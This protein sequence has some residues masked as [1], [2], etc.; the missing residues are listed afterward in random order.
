MWWS[1]CGQGGG[2]DLHHAGVDFLLIGVERVPGR[3]AVWPRRQLRVLPE[4]RPAS[5]AARASPRAAC[6][7][8]GRTCPLNLAIQSLGAW[9]G[10]WAV[11]G[12]VVGEERL[13]RARP[14][15]ACGSGRWR[16]RPCP[17]RRCSPV[18]SCGGSTG[19]VFSKSAGCH[20]SGV[21]AEEAVE[22]VEA[23]PGGPQVERPGLAGVPVGHVVVLAEPRR[24]CSR[25][26]CRISANVPQ[27]LGM[28]EL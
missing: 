24:C 7:S 11:P 21:A 19:L 17:G 14:R 1:Q 12:R 26:A 10:A 28:S 6:P 9:C 25:S 23:Q 22:V 27:L 18:R 8:P 20:W 15:A 2:V 5:S 4:R 16:G 13:V 3:D